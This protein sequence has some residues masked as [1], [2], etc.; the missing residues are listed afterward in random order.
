M[1]W[2]IRFPTSLSAVKPNSRVNS[3]LMRKMHRS[4]VDN[5]DRFGRVLDDL[6]EVG[7][8]HFER[9][10]GGIAVRG[11]VARDWN[12]NVGRNRRA[13]CSRACR[14][15]ATRGSSAELAAGAIFSPIQ[16]FP[17]VHWR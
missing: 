16:S 12:R 14:S 17:S 13:P 9:A 3:A 4:F 5:T 7:F 15:D 8:L 11:R 1:S 10:F 6:F 2:S